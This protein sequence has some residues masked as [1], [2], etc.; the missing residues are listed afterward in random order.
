VASLAPDRTHWRRCAYCGT[1]CPRYACHA[2]ADL[3]ALDPEHWT[4]VASRG[5]RSWRV[6]LTPR[7]RPGKGA[8]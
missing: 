8:P 6:A 3:P 5:W 7:V 2:H 1:P 4:R